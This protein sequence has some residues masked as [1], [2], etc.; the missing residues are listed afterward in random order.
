MK[1]RED[2]NMETIHDEDWSDIEPEYYMKVEGN[3][4]EGR[5]GTSFLI[6]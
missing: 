4:T 3:D 6:N 5:P 2:N 1:W